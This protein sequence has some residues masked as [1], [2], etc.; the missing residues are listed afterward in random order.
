MENNREFQ[1]CSIDC[2]STSWLSGQI[3]S[4]FTNGSGTSN[5]VSGPRTDTDPV[6]EALKRLEEQNRYL[7]QLAS[8]QS[9]LLEEVLKVLK[10]KKQD[11]GVFPL[12]SVED[13]EAA[14][15]L[16]LSKNEQEVITYLRS[17]F[18]RRPIF[19]FIDEIFGDELILKINWDGAKN[20]VAINSYKLF[21]TFF[22]DALKEENLSYEAY[23]ANFKK[24]FHKRK[25]YFYRKT[26][27]L[28][29]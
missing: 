18:G 27:K 8:K 10:P 12:D 29:K 7:L 16:I 20:K 23:E 4:I 25:A 1:F 22:F 26:Y 5:I 2:A 6:T 11:L 21:N 17:K 14:E 19:K 3:G 24:A 15:T 28:K 13:L 9:V